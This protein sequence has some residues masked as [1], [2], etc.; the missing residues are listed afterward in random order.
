[1]G[2]Q[3]LG[4]LLLKLFSKGELAGTVVWEL[5]SAAFLDG[6]GHDDP[7]A[8]KLVNCGSA[9][10]ARNKIAGHI[11][12]VAES[13]GLIC[14][15]AQPYIFPISTGGNCSVFLP[16]EAY[17]AMTEGTELSS[18]CLSPAELQRGQG[19]AKLLKDWAEH[20]DVQFEGDLSQVGV[21]G[22]HCDG[23]QYTTT[24]RAGGSRSILTGSMNI[25]SAES[26]A[27]KHKR[28]PL[29]VLRKSRLCGCG[30]QG[31]HTIQEIMAVVSWSFQ[32]LASGFSPSCRHDRSAWTQQDEAA[33]QPSGQ[34]IRRAALLQVRGDWEWLEQCFR[35]RSVNSESFCWMCDAVQRQEG[36]LSF[37]DFRPEAAHRST[38]ISHEMYM[39]SCVAEGSHPSHLFLIP[40]LKI[41]HLAVDAMHSGDLGTFADAVGS[42]FWLEATHKPWHRNK[43]EGLAALNK[44]LDN[45]YR[46]HAD[47]DFSKLTPLVWSQIYAKSNGYP[48]LKAKAAQ[49]RQIA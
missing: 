9:G 36:P 33:R 5:A 8:R 4:R 39:A 46:A 15:K 12:K 37:H 16:H 44:D 7:L 19:L 32:C 6:W 1:M 23:V 27:I 35:L 13:E 45:Y 2:G 22:I 38:L 48:A 34:P 28:Q 29:F 49:T 30:C 47:R 43:A 20:M 41:E 26:A 3:K 40:G 14:S 17:Q 10:R 42:L 18:W 31:F 11:V 21:A 24:I 25:V